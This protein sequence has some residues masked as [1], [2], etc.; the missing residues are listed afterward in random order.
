[1][2]DKMLKGTLLVSLV[3]VMAIG[4]PAVARAQTGVPLG[5]IGGMFN[6]PNSFKNMLSGLPGM[7]GGFGGA[8]QVLGQI[9]M[10]L[11]DQFFNL[12]GREMIP[13][14]FVL[15]ATGEYVDN[16]TVVDAGETQTKRYYP[17]YDYYTA[18]L[19]YIKGNHSMNAGYPYCIV[20]RSANTDVNVT[21]TVGMSVTVAIWDSDKTLVNTI[22]R[23]VKTVKKVFAMMNDGNGDIDA[24]IEEAVSSIMYL[25]IHIND[26]ITG[27]ELIMFNPI[28]YETTRVTGNFGEQHQWYIDVWNGNNNVREPLNPAIVTDMKTKADNEANEFMSW[29]A[30][31]SLTPADYDTSFGQFSFDLVQL[32][33]KRLYVSLDMK[34]IVN[35]LNFGSGS[36]TPNPAAILKDLDI[37]FYL[38][39]HHL[40]GGAFFDDKNSNR[41]I[42]INYVNV[43]DGNGNVITTENG[44]VVQR[45]DSSEVTHFIGMKDIRGGV[46]WRMPQVT[47]DGKSLKWGAMFDEVEIFWT[48]IG[49]DPEQRSRTG[50]TAVLDYIDL[51]FTFTAGADIAILNMDG[52]ES[53]ITGKDAT[54][55]L[56]QA[57]GEWKDPVSGLPKA[58]GAIDGNLTGLDFSVVYVSTL[59]HVHFQ[60]ET[61]M[62]ALGAPG[63]EKEVWDGAAQAVVNHFEN[64]K[65][66]FGTEAATGTAAI[67]MVSRVDIAGPKYDI[68]D[69]GGSTPHPFDASTQIIPVGLFTMDAQAGMDYTDTNMVGGGFQA[70][71][72]LGIEFSVMLYSV[73]Y[74]EFSNYSGGEVV[75]DP[76]FS[77]FMTFEAGTY[78]AIILLVGVVALVGVAAILITRSKNNR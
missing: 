77:I 67:P 75:H 57:F 16:M 25:L 66:S 50:A 65:L 32:W 29:L 64:N 35:L 2:A 69:L 23:I 15:N 26:I 43:T 63:N 47:N 17:D 11:A 73:N 4:V 59:L 74:P 12:T 72:F 36:S 18:M 55:K 30:G 3:L 60:G 6:D 62:K 61:L 34:E 19:P 76:T 8:G 71:A 68:Y 41:L 42:D 51:G 45:P 28:T 14:L 40:I 1:M 22:D 38:I 78:W 58:P 10:L 48:P 7:L 5:D 54:V 70:N 20:N 24:A 27:D 56:D 49:M 13:G 46:T 53:G 9:F 33:M 52:T 37:E 21:K 39:W 31:P 44:T